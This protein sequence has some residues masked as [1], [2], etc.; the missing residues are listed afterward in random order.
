MQGLLGMTRREQS[1]F[2]DLIDLATMLPWWAGVLLA[3]VCFFA[4]HLFAEA[5]VA[6]AAPIDDPGQ[7]TMKGLLRTVAVIGQYLVAAAF[8]FGAIGGGSSRTRARMR[9]GSRRFAPRA[10]V[11]WPNALHAMA[12]MRAIPSWAARFSPGCRRTRDF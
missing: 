4:S 9:M 7:A 11:R 5:P 8:V 2:E 12:P 6:N 1:F 3:I 10:E